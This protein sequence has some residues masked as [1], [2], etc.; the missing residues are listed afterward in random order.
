[1]L[2]V[3]QLKFIHLN[4]VVC[5]IKYAKENIL[6]IQPGRLKNTY[7]IANSRW[8]CMIGISI[9]YKEKQN[10]GTKDLELGVN[11]SSRL[12]CLSS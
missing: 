11:R 5:L 10:I 12:L 7:K 9:Y 3:C 6:I 8:Q 4:L 1:M 2:K